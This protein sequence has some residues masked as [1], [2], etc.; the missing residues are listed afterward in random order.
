MI[1]RFQAVDPQK[2]AKGEQKSRFTEVTELIRDHGL[3]VCLDQRD[4]NGV[5]AMINSSV[6][7]RGCRITSSTARYL[8]Q[9][10]GTDL[11]TLRNELDKL[12]A[13]RQ[14]AGAPCR[15]VHDGRRGTCR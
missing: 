6:T 8:V 12:T 7:R 11:T 10:C 4:E 2:N 5:T 14:N 13:V 9:T 15:S 1:F 3:V